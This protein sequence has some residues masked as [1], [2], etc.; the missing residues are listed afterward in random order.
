MTNTRIPVFDGHNDTLLAL[1]KPQPG[2]E[3]RTFFEESD[4]GALDLPRARRGGLVGGIFAIF[5]PDPQVGMNP[6]MFK[7]RPT[8][9]GWEVTYAEPIDPAYA[10]E[11]TTAVIAR[12]SATGG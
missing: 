7:R 10:R 1:H 11:L 2:H 9:D 5:A 3:K 4:L 6:A 12:A 8:P